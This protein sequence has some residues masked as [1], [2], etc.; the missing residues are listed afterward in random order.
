M[1]KHL[2]LAVSFLSSLSAQAITSQEAYDH[3][4]YLYGEV[5]VKDPV[6]NHLVQNFCN[7]AKSQ[8][9]FYEDNKIFMR[10][11]K[12]LLIT[13]IRTSQAA[14][15][16]DPEEFSQ[17]FVEMVTFVIASQYQKEWEDLNPRELPA[18]IF[19]N[20]ITPILTPTFTMANTQARAATRSLS[21][22]SIFSQQATILG[23]LAAIKAGIQFVKGGAD[24]ADRIVTLLENT[25]KDPST[26]GTLL[27]ALTQQRSVRRS[28]AV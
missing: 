12:E 13:V 8:T 16:R 7:T 3:F 15:Y 11:L 18:G 26:L 2:M 21:L 28:R 19:Q 25:I 22:L 27:S 5:E 17:D 10:E 6:M 4:V 23:Y 14:S 20:W 1:N 9:G 24:V